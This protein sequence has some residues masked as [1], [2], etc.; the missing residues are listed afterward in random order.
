MQQATPETRQKL[1]EKVFKHNK[2]VENHPA[3]SRLFNACRLD[4]PFAT[5]AMPQ[6]VPRTGSAAER[7]KNRH[8]SLLENVVLDVLTKAEGVAA[9]ESTSPEKILVDM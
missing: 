9:H 8:I 7:V 2:Q 4:F 6:S 5:P 3:I 1:E